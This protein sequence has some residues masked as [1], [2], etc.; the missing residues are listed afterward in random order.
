MQRREQRRQR[1]LGDASASRQRVYERSDAL[2]LDEL[3][4]YGVEYRMVH[5]EGRNRRFRW[6]D[7]NPKLSRVPLGTCEGSSALGR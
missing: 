2:V 7:G 4:N 6:V 1:R 5:D 3:A